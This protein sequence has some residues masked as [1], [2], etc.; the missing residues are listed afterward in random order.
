MVL[1][2]LLKPILM[3]LIQV[4]PPTRENE[5]RLCT[6]LQERLLRKLGKNAYPFFFELPLN[7]PCSVTLQVFINLFIRMEEQ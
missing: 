4:Y 2:F 1:F 3:D 7:S 6:R 5:R